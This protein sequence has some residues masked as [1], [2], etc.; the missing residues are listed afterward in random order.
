M[1][2]VRPA[3]NEMNSCLSH[4]VPWSAAGTSDM[5]ES[6]STE[7]PSHVELEAHVE[8]VCFVCCESTGVM[9]RPCECTAMYMHLQC[10]RQLMQR[11]PSHRQG[12]P[13]C[14]SPYLN[15]LRTA[16]QRRLTFDGWM[17]VLYAVGILVIISMGFYMLSNWYME[18]DDTFYKI[19]IFFFIIAGL[20]SC[21]GRHVFRAVPCSTVSKVTVKLAATNVIGSTRVPPACTWTLAPNTM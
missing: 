11:I 8:R 3:W 19:A 9:V 1:H 4:V 20:L 12:C 18:D 2:T 16:K 10:Q 21:F 5:C 17:M 13:V 15:V 7:A 6:P 14:Q